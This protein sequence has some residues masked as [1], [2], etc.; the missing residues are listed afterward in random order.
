MLGLLEELLRH[1][2]VNVQNMSCLEMHSLLLAGRDCLA[3]F[4]AKKQFNGASE[5][6]AQISHAAYSRIEDISRTATLEKVEALISGTWLG[7]EWRR[8]SLEIVA[9]RG[10]PIVRLRACEALWKRF[11]TRPTP[12]LVTATAPR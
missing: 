3:A 11:G 12:C 1:P 9:L 8:E 5:H 4:L 7:P 10:T 6:L 2:V